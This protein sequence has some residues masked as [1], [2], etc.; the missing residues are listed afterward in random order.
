MKEV[1]VYQTWITLKFNSTLSLILI[2]LSTCANANTECESLFPQN[3]NLVIKRDLSFF[4]MSR[5][6]KG[7]PKILNGHPVLYISAHRGAFDAQIPGHAE[8]FARLSHSRS[9]VKIDHSVILDL[10]RAQTD[11]IISA[12]YQSVQYIDASNADH[13][14]LAG[15]G[16]GH[17]PLPDYIINIIYEPPLDRNGRSLGG[18]ITTFG[19]DQRNYTHIL[20]E[21]RIFLEKNGFIK[22]KLRPRIENGSVLHQ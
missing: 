20:Q 22:G 11:E 7:I 9:D 3:R 13:R 18:P 16:A 5:E 15:P 4:E 1:A 17:T 19:L 2:I 14:L 6:L 12:L 8:I 10:S 21:L